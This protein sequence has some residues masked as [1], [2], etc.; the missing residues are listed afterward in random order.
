MDSQQFLTFFTSPPGAA[1]V[2]LS[3]FE[4]LIDQYPWCQS[5]HSLYALQ[6]SRNGSPLF[7]MKLRKAAA[8]SGDRARLRFLLATLSVETRP[9]PIQ[10]PPETLTVPFAIEPTPPVIPLTLI[11]APEEVR[12]DRMTTAELLAIVKK[13]LAEIES[14]VEMVAG[15][16]SPKGE[17][18]SKV[19]L[20]DKFI[21]EEPRISKP[22]ATFFSPAESAF[23]SNFDDEEVVSETL[24]Q[25]YARQGNIQKAIH[26]YEKLSL[27][28]QEKSRYFAA[29]IEKLGS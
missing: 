10:T 3:E 19:E 27:L 22:K 21:K 14:G 8:Y 5:A 24:A 25:L 15:S 9:R 4:E 11:E 18:L 2:Q 28:N 29:Q 13:R 12:T 7:Q 16:G 26:I 20:I 17:N 1:H 6:L 23:R